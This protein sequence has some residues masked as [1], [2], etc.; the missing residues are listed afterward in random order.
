MKILTR[1]FKSEMKFHNE[2]EKHELTIAAKRFRKA[3][4]RGMEVTADSWPKLYAKHICDRCPSAL[5]DIVF[6]KCRN[7]Y[8]KRILFEKNFKRLG[9]IYSRERR[10][11][12]PSV[13][14]QD[15]FGGNILKFMLWIAQA[16]GTA[17]VAALKNKSVKNYR[18]EGS[19]WIPGK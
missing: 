2:R 19:Q 13:P 3:F 4:P 7:S 15:S 11:K 14:S 10:R 17:L 18:L 9:K 5:L 6:S 1:D 12:N 16:E 8:S